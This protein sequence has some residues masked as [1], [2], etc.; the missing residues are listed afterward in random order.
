WSAGAALWLLFAAFVEVQR[1]LF[2]LFVPNGARRVLV[3]T[4]TAAILVAILFGTAAAV[5]RLPAAAVLAASCGLFVL[6]PL[7]GRRAGEATAL[8]M[9]PPVPRTARRSLLVVG[10][11]GVSWDLLAAGASDGSLPV[12][13]RLL[14]EG[15]AGPLASLGPY[16]RAALWTSAA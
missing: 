5:P 2:Y 14:R 3:G 8:P 4:F 15:A 13:G 9:P 6:P 10:L 12:L 7:L 1:S 11:E 16:D